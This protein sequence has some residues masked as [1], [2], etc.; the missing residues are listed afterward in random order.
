M[1]VKSRT[2]E[3]DAETADVLEHEAQARGLTLPEFLRQLAAEELP[4]PPD[5]E[6]MRA[7]GGGPWSPQALAEDAR[8]FDEFERTG[9]GI[10]FEDVAA[11]MESWGTED[12]L[13]VPK[14][15]RF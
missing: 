15:R 3:L 4:L 2:I 14:P 12:E 10:A 11:W 8:V 6:E 5:M 1:T 7:A 13:P 9:K